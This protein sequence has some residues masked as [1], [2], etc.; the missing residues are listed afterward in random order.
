MTIRLFEAWSTTKARVPSRLK[1]TSAAL[2]PAGIIFVTVPAVTSTSATWLTGLSMVTNR[3]RPFGD[4]ANP[5]KCGRLA[6]PPADG[7]MVALALAA[8]AAGV[9]VPLAVVVAFADGVIVPLAV[10][11]AFADGVIVPLAVVVAFADGVVDAL[12]VVVALADGVPIA[13]ALLV[14][15]PLDG[16]IDA[17]AVPRRT[18]LT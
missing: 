14:D 6:T 11:V 5:V 18:T 15:A 9:M 4:M 2:V 7:V 16:V 3:L 1:V 8:P 13:F 17:L 10:V 12:E